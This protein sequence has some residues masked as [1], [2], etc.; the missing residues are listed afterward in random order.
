LQNPAVVACQGQVASIGRS[1][2]SVSIAILG[3]QKGTKISPTEY[4]EIGNVLLS[5][6]YVDFKK[7]LFRIID[8][9]LK[10]DQVKICKF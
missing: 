9:I 3:K 4:N 6:N 8:L 5:T 10:L 7:K 1:L 2:T